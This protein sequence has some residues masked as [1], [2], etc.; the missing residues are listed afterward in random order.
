VTDKLNSAATARNHSLS[1]SSSKR[2][3]A[4]G[5]PLNTD[6]VNASTWLSTRTQ[7]TMIHIKDV[8]RKGKT[9]LGETHTRVYFTGF[10]A[11]DVPT[12]FFSAQT[13]QSSN[14]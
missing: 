14:Q 13:H 8:M 3:T 11:I 6:S 12:D 7:L 9:E 1:L 5:F 2:H 4:A 10:F